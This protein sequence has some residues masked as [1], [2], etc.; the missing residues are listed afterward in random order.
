MECHTGYENEEDYS[1]NSKVTYHKRGMYWK[2]YYVWF[3]S[4]YFNGNGNKDNYRMYV[5]IIP[6]NESK[7]LWWWWRMSHVRWENK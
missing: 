4:D 7:D 6:F 3:E 1:Y 2:G 5:S